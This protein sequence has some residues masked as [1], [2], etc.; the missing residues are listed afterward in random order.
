[1]DG[2]VG[3]RRPPLHPRLVIN[4][5]PLQEPPAEVD[6]FDAAPTMVEPFRRRSDPPADQETVQAPEPD[7]PLA[8]A[9]LRDVQRPVVRS[10]QEVPATRGQVRPT[11]RVNV[12]PRS[13]RAHVMVNERN[14]H[15][16]LPD[17]GSD[18]LRRL[19]RT[20]PAARTPGGARLERQ[21]SRWSDQRGRSIAFSSGAALQRRL[22]RLR[23]HRREQPLGVVRLFG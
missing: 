9:Q 3:L 8:E 7:S 6:P 21:R 10:L 14:C 22:L 12:R 17:R 15:R 2:G 20:S 11:D 19:V 18:P 16:S 23:L 4:V 5:E 13:Q 1:M